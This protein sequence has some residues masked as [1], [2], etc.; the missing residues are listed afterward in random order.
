MSPANGAKIAAA[1]LVMALA[2]AMPAAADVRRFADAAND[3]STS[4]DIR[5]V[6]VDNSTTARDQVIVVVRQVNVRLGDAIE[7][8][9]DTRPGDPGPEY[10]IGGATASEYLLQH[11]EHWKGHGRVVP[12][13]C[14]YSLRINAETDRSRAV[15]QRS[16]LRHPGKVRVAIRA[17][18]G[19]PSTSRDWAPA[20]RTWSRWVRR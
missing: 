19:F 2:L 6:R 9:L 5:S 13:R 14:G 15:I 4:V 17:V 12:F 10:S 18:R 11:R 7:I 20:R 16:C 3:A 8:F 1:V